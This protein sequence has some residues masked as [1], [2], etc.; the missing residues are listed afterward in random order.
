MMI[1]QLF[2]FDGK[3]ES[4]SRYFWAPRPWSPLLMRGLEAWAG[5]RVVRCIYW[6]HRELPGCRSIVGV[7][8]WLGPMVWTIGL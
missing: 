7:G 2:G 5:P 8:P 4:M 3:V 6:V 1:F